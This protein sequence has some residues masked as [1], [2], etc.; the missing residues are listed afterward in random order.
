[1]ESLPSEREE[2]L[3]VPTKSF[4]KLHKPYKLEKLSYDSKDG[5]VKPVD[6]NSMAKSQ[7]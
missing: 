2:L 5:F 3:P 1:M 6:F 4:S 7:Q